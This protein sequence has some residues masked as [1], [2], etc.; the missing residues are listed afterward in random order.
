MGRRASVLFSGLRIYFVFN[1]M[2][3]NRLLCPVILTVRH[4]DSTHC[5][6]W[7]SLEADPAE[8]LVCHHQ[9][10]SRARAPLGKSCA[11]LRSDS[12]VGRAGG[13]LINR[14]ATSPSTVDNQL[15]I[16]MGDSCDTPVLL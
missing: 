11:C 9:A 6:A 5:L 12:G 7:R 3:E 10:L 16:K 4:T 2:F 1:E 13:I 8:E 14:E 15:M